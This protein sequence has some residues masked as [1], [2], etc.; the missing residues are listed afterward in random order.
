MIDRVRRQPLAVAVEAADGVTPE[1]LATVQHHPHAL[2]LASRPLGY[3]SDPEVL[4]RL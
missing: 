2:S 4:K 1:Y 3:E